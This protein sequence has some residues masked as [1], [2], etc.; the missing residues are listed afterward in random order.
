MDSQTY[1]LG[2]CDGV[3]S[4]LVKRCDGK[5]VAAYAQRRTPNGKMQLG[6]H[7]IGRCYCAKPKTL[8]WTPCKSDLAMVKLVLLGI[9]GVPVKCYTSGKHTAVVYTVNGGS[10]GTTIS[11]G[12]VFTCNTVPDV[13][14]ILAHRM[15]NVC[16]Y[17]DRWAV[18]VLSH[19]DQTHM[20]TRTI[21]KR[22][23]GKKH[24]KVEQGVEYVYTDAD[25]DVYVDGTKRPTPVVP[26]KMIK[27]IDLAGAIEPNIEST[28]QRQAVQRKKHLLLS[29]RPQQE[30]SR[31]PKVFPENEDQQGSHSQPANVCPNTSSPRGGS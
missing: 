5:I 19:L 9:L 10:R 7:P 23:D 29:A 11:T 28:L 12:L 27:G 20:P 4:L 31:L 16:V 24:D 6:T 1:E 25:W 14:V 22:K 26:L 2:L 13:P 17:N 18:D 30:R 15:H 21:V 3:D 8:N